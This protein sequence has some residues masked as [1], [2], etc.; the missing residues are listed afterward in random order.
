MR[1]NAL[2]HEMQQL[3][4]PVMYVSSQ[5]NVRY[6][7][8]FCGTNGHLVITQDSL[9]LLTDGRY[10][11][12][13]EQE[14]PRFAVRLLS[15]PISKALAPYFGGMRVGYESS[16]LSD[17]AA[18]KLK[19]ACEGTEWVPL[20]QFG[21][22]ARSVKDESE[23][24][25]ITRA[26]EIADA[27]FEAL[28]PQIK[29]GVSERDLR[30]ELEYLMDKFGSER[31]AFETIVACGVRSSLPHAV[32]TTQ[33]VSNDDLITFDFGAVYDGYASDITR[34]VCIGSP[35]LKHIFE[36]V[37][38]VQDRLVAAVRPGITCGELDAYQRKLFCDM[39]LDQYVVHSLGHGVGLE[40]HEEPR[41]SPNSETV[42]VPNMV[43]T[44]EPG[45]YLPGRGGVRSED[46]V[47]VTETGAVRLT[48]TPH[49]LVR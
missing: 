39:G 37:L 33:T 3:G 18:S 46:T 21:Q 17:D 2:R 40:I 14:A 28:L 31:P 48:H 11:E 38:S 49:H 26:C 42:L 30:R 32:P 47:L 22:S 8:G 29:P 27:A 25:A 24:S 9:T 6:Y 15:G 20:A 7:S 12:Q 43:I 44:I 36:A 35:A 34:T 4:I 16:S 10:T 13:A 5:E 41:V 1:I 19:V 23:I 45:L